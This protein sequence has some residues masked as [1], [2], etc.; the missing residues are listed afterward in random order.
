MKALTA[1]RLRKISTASYISM[2]ARK[3]TPIVWIKMPDGGPHAVEVD[4]DDVI[5][6]SRDQREATV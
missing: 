3:P 4:E 5:R 1:F 6:S 2:P